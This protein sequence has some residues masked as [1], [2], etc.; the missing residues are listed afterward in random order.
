MAKS[1]TVAPTKPV[2][3]ETKVNDRVLNEILELV[4]NLAEEAES[5][6]LLALGV[7]RV[8]RGGKINWETVGGPE[9]FRHQLLAGTSYLANA[10]T[11]D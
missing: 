1:K 6:D 7:I 2:L 11:K 4:D 8:N 10:L 9:G 5:G 3:V